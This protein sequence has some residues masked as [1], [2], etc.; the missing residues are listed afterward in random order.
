MLYTLL[1]LH[2]FSVPFLQK[3]ALVEG[4]HKSPDVFKADAVCVKDCLL[5]KSAKDHSNLFCW[6]V[7]V[8]V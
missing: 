1:I 8:P 7:S 6:K 2:F 4:N 5:S 3:D